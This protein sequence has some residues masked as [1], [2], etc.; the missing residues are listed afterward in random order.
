[1]LRLFEVGRPKP[2]VVPVAAERGVLWTEATSSAAVLPVTEPTAP[3]SSVVE[4]RCLIKFFPFKFL[5]I[6]D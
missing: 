6:T 5:L 3:V 2:T 1:M 4:T